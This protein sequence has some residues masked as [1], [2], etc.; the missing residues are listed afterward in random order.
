MALNAVDA[1]DA[2][3]EAK[4]MCNGMTE[5][6]WSSDDVCSTVLQAIGH[7]GSRG[8]DFI[9]FHS[10]RA[11]IELRQ[12]SS[13]NAKWLP[14]LLVAIFRH[15]DYMEMLTKLVYVYNLGVFRLT[16]K[17]FERGFYRDA[18]VRDLIH[19]PD[20]ATIIS[21]AMTCVPNKAER[22]SHRSAITTGERSWR[23]IPELLRN[24]W[25]MNQLETTTDDIR[26]QTLE[27][28]AACLRFSNGPVAHTLHTKERNYDAKILALALG[29]T[30]SR[31]IR[32]AREVC[33]RLDIKWNWTCSETCVIATAVKKCRISGNT[34]DIVEWLCSVN[35]DFDEHVRTGRC[36]RLETPVSW[37][38]TG[39]ES[40]DFEN[41]LEQPTRY[42]TLVE[43]DSR[44]GH[45]FHHAYSEPCFVLA[46]IMYDL[47]QLAS[48]RLYNLHLQQVLRFTRV[49]FY[50]T[51]D[52]AGD[53][54]GRRYI[55][56]QY[57]RMLR[58]FVHGTGSETSTLFDMFNNQGLWPFPGTDFFCPFLNQR[59]LHQAQLAL[60]IVHHSFKPMFLGRSVY[61]VV[62]DY[63]ANDSVFTAN[64][65]VDI[66]LSEPFLRHGVGKGRM[67]SFEP[68]SEGIAYMFKKLPDHGNT[69]LGPAVHAFLR[70]RFLAPLKLMRSEHAS[71]WHYLL[72]PGS[73]DILCAFLHCTRAQ[74]PLEL[75]LS[76]VSMM[77]S[78][79]PVR[80]LCA[81]GV[82]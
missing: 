32:N 1:A 4:R 36:P 50:V 66:C 71:F 13:S 74:L 29:G 31:C 52:K 82:P 73:K 43:W 27:A 53:Q 61:A 35:S 21:R 80:F 23:Y 58:R 30:S 81:Q 51:V 64:L 25:Q 48:V 3:G 34:V 26:A 76:I 20:C 12:C 45:L 39:K 15:A 16:S 49:L 8:L 59:R 47:A 75:Q 2:Y 41:A 70:S 46:A 24:L 17:H 9:L 5:V 11:V 54:A 67:M 72:T 28:I 65:T 6:H 19:E 56:C 77:V 10:P 69:R 55:I 7:C 57:F 60:N 42:R 38:S 78:S 44:A 37:M 79:T 40:S 33:D 62:A 63:I 22:A 68:W 14:K 18:F